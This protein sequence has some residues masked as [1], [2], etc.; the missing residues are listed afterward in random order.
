MFRDGLFALVI[1][2][3]GGS[4]LMANAATPLKTPTKISSTSMDRTDG[5]VKKGQDKLFNLRGLGKRCID[6]SQ[7]C[8]FY[9]RV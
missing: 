8:R 1:G 3:M 4:V 9:Y 6:K 2:F 7:I 5:T